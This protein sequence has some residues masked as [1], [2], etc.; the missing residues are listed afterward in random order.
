[1]ML[2]G[3]TVKYKVIANGLKNRKMVPVTESSLDHADPERDF[4][5]SI[6]S[7]SEAHKKEFDKS[8]KVAGFTGLTTNKLVFD[9]D[10][11]TN[12]EKAK[13][14]AVELT[15]RLIQKGV[16][17][18]QIQVYYSG[19]KGF[20]II[21][22]TNEEFTKPE[23]DNTI[24]SLAGDLEKFD[25]TVRDENRILRIPLT[26]HP[27]TKR[28]KIPLTVDELTSMPMD[29]I[30]SMADK[31]DDNWEKWQD[32]L[33]SQASQIELPP[34]IKQY[35]TIS[36]T[37]KKTL[38]N[39]AI[40]LDDKPNLANKPK[41]MS[42]ARFTLQEG[43]FES[44]ERN[45]AFMILAATY[46]A[47]GYNKELAYNMLKATNR[48]QSRRTGQAPYSTDELWINVIE[49]VYSNTWRGAVYSEKENALLQKII[50]K[51]G[52]EKEEE[53]VK[54][55][56]LCELGGDS[57]TRYA[58][59]FYETRIYTGLKEL[60]EKFPICAGSNV[61]IVGAASSGKTALSLNILEQMKNTGANSVFASLDMSKSRLYEK[62]LYKVTGGTK[63]R[64]EIYQDYLSGKGNYY[65]ELVKESFPNTFVFAKSA[66]TI[67]QLRNYIDRVQEHTGKP[68]RL[69]LID[70]FERVN[71]ERSDDTAAS[72]DVAAGIQ[73]LIAD[74]PELTPITL[75]QPNK[76]SLGGG[77]DKPILNYTSI[78]G[79]GFVYQAARQILSLWR[80]FF[81]PEWADYDQ[82]MEMA[83]LK[84]DLG[85]LDTFKW[86]WDGKT[87][88]INP[89]SPDQKM[90]YDQW[91]KEKEAKEKGIKDDGD[92]F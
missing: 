33:E 81:S 64:D 8:K 41:H 79:S 54:P 11:K 18:D 13:Q 75:Y 49:V 15:S 59:S 51:Y 36:K 31:V 48:L 47:L 52:L 88:S 46:R 61:A 25:K 56:V 20:H 43:F 58:K 9:F 14:D 2:A 40:S 28:F 7:Y 90:Q 85:E 73:D 3:G 35:K 34:S 27:E 78:K 87:G 30:Q 77:P 29:A 6:F 50:T 42:A 70:Y 26:K 69:L 68:V 72:K 53:K 17:K 57:F 37:E 39:V 24:D 23:F 71:S 62:L 44:G 83:I 92:P 65:D 10:S 74:Y 66:P 16:S 80:P 91:F 55:A 76:F 32:I 4:Y 84:N 12:V 89:M 21:L 1:M 82:F 60:D 67:E 5:E 63:T 38:D 19:Q 86:A 22:N 45:H